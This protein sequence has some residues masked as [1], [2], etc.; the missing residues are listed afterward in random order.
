MQGRGASLWLPSSL[1]I[2][3]SSVFV[4]IEASSVFVGIE[5]SSVFVV[6]FVSFARG[7]ETRAQLFGRTWGNPEIQRSVSDLR[8]CIIWLGA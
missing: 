5:A 1:G 4:G 6:S 2:E 7:C 3:A 8:L